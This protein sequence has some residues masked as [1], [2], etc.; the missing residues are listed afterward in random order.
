MEIHGS[1]K[2]NSAEISHDEE[3]CENTMPSYEEE[4]SKTSE[5]RHNETEN[6]ECTKGENSTTNFTQ[7]R[8]CGRR[9][10]RLWKESKSTLI[11]LF[12]SC[13][14]CARSSSTDDE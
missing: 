4:T 13:C 12:T 11:K 3:S 10:R 5:I 2:L 9:L 6:M 8:S 7:D 1:D 14:P